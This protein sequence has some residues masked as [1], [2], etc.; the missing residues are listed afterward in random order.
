G[1]IGENGAG[2]S[3]LFEAILY[4]LFGRDESNKAL[5]RSTLS[6]PKAPVELVLDFSVGEVGYRVKRE[7][8]GKAMTVGAELLRNDELIAKGVAAVNDEI[9]KVLHMERD[10][11]KRS[12]FSGQKELSQ[13]SDSTGEARK[14]MVRR[15]LG[16]DTLDEVQTRVNS[17]VRDLS[18]Q[19]AGQ[20]QNLL[21]DEER[22]ALQEELASRADTLKD[23]EAALKNEAAQLAALD[24]RYRQER[25]KF[26]EEEQRAQR[27]HARS[28]ELAQAQERQQGFARQQ[29]TLLG[30]IAELEQQ[31]ARQETLRGTFADY[32]TERSTFERLDAERQ[33]ALNRDAYA[34]QIQAL[35]APLRQSQ[36]KLATLDADLLQREGVEEKLQAAQEASDTFQQQ[37]EEKLKHLRLLESQISALQERISD[38]RSKVAQ[39]EAIGREGQCPTC[40]QPVRDAYD[41]VLRQLDEEISRLQNAEKAD[42]EAQSAQVIEAGKALRSQRDEA[43]KT[44]QT[45]RSE[46]ARL[47]ELARQ[48]KAEAEHLGKMQTEVARLEVILREIGEAHFDQAAYQH[49]KDRLAH[50]EPRYRD[51]LSQQNYLD[52][53]LPAARQSLRQAAEAE[54]ETSKKMAT[55]AHDLAAIGYDSARHEAAKHSLTQFNDT[56]TAQS[57]R[58]RALEKTGLELQS[59][60]AQAQSRL[61]NDALILARISQKM[62]EAELLRKL[63]DMLGLFKTEILEKVSPGISREASELFTRIT[64]GKYEGIYVDENFDFSIA[65]GGQYYPI[66]RFSGGEVDLANFCLRIA[67]TKAIMELSGATAD[68]RLEFL[69]FDEIFGSQDEERRLEMMLALN[70]LQEQFRQIYIVS[71][72]ESLKDYF[73][74][75][76]EVR[77]AEEGSTVVWR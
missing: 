61:Q 6:P 8:R 60:Q 42:L 35:Q 72:I 71:H 22:L 50:L 15:M 27:H 48:R 65:D 9:S 43:E 28:R 68:R 55:L 29:E 44:A 23:N 63:A 74:H 12:V 39:I 37:R 18:S 16:L 59:Q 40:F 26:E 34:S 7:F 4:C 36:Q 49:L 1:V 32:D 62:E 5:V 69:A 64:K 11:F 10:A 38:R 31:Q 46:L 52:R 19:V 33:R 13:L 73:P 25:E 57:E 66:E 75:L 77:A 58:V 76:L 20:R 3:T 41:D 30:K 51:F 45:L 53:E 47:G 14:R 17:D 24:A 54:A 21:S 67:I 56:R 2:K 70:Y